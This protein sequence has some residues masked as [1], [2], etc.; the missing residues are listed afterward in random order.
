MNSLEEFAQTLGEA[1]IERRDEPFKLKSGDLSHYYIDLRQGHAAGPG[2][3]QSSRFML[4]LTTGLPYNTV[5]GEGVD[6]RAVVSGM[7]MASVGVEGRNTLSGRWA[8]SDSNAPPIEDEPKNGHGFRKSHMTGR[9][10]L[11]VDGTLTTGGSLAGLVDMIRQ[12]E[13]IVEHAAVVV[14]RSGGRSADMAHE[15]GVTLHALFHFDEANGLLV[16]TPEALTQI[17]PAPQ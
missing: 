3:M 7:V 14:D 8:T 2:L 5:A 12:A 17:A 16:P 15:I 4:K 13:G 10:V 11:A 9:Q 1:S 6:G